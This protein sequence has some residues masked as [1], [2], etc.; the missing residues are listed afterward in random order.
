[1]TRKDYIVLAQVLG[2]WINDHNLN[3]VSTTPSDL[4]HRVCQVLQDDNPRFKAERFQAAVD[5]R[6]EVS[7]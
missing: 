2:D 4:V 3:P 1:M 5:A 6:I 7:Q